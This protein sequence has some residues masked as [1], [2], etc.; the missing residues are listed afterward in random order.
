MKKIWEYTDED[1]G[2]G[3]LFELYQINSDF[4]VIASGG[5]R[6]HIGAVS[7]NEQTMAAPGHKENII[8]SMMAGEIQGILQSTLDEKTKN[9]NI[10]VISG[11]HVDNITKAQ[12]DAVV[13]M[14]KAAAKK[15]ADVV[16]R[17]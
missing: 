13:K 7:L 12:I 2:V 5:H 14:C 17:N 16:V 1:M 3:I 9:P 4:L 6:P 10:C 11:I 15:I 8:T